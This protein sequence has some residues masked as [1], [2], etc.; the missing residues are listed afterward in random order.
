MIGWIEFGRAGH[1]IIEKPMICW[2]ARNSS[3]VCS[4]A[5]GARVG[6]DSWPK[7]C[8]LLGHWA[9]NCGALHLP[10]VVY[11]YSCIVLKVDELP[12]LSSEGL[13]LP[14][15]YSRHNLFPQLWLPPH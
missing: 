5:N 11:N 7:V 14:D 6:S 12:V 13:P 1:Q 3:V 2:G 10:L 8:A 15:D 4:S 9:C